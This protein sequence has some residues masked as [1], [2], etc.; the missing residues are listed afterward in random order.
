MTII[1]G[2]IALGILVMLHEIGHFIA[3]RL[4]GVEVEALSVGMG[5]VLLHKKIGGVDYRLSLFPFGGYCAMKGENEFKEAVENGSSVIS[6][7]LKS[8]YGTYPLRR[9]II[10]FAGPFTNLL[11]GFL[12]F[13]MIAGIGYD[14]YTAGT[15]V[16]MADEKY[17]NIRSTAHESG[18]ESG[19]TVISID[20]VPVKNFSEMAEY[21]TLHPDEDVSITVLRNG[22]EKRFNVHVLLDKDT[23]A[24]KIGIIS[25]PSSI[26]KEHYGADSFINSIKL[27]AEQTWNV[28]SWTIK[29]V[30]IL[31][32]GINFTKALSGPVRIS[33]IMGDTVKEGYKESFSVG[34]VSTLQIL[35]IISISL[36]FTNMLPIPVLDGGLILFA[37]IEWISRRKMNPKVLL[38]IQYAGIALLVSLMAFA[39]ICD[40]MFFIKK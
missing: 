29:S 17:E 25:D 24:G 3:A 7:D 2:L 14:Y 18:M 13:C 32:K 4:N 33:S 22:E 35:A 5:P 27:G 37:L 20:D 10:A 16:T 11:L 36:F 15:T 30:G 38:Y 34:T 9:L 31:F 19:D 6:S 40:F 23:G 39:F 12:F 26:K 1:I 28:A 21:I 8:F